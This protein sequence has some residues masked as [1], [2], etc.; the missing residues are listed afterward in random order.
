VIDA[1]GRA[2][3]SLPATSS[4][5]GMACWRWPKPTT[6]GGQGRPGTLAGHAG[7]GDRCARRGAATGRAHRRH[8]ARDRNQ[9]LSGAPAAHPHVGGAPNGRAAA[10]KRLGRL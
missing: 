2:V 1:V 4:S 7:S 10:R 5:S 3:E 9:D 6:P 8:P